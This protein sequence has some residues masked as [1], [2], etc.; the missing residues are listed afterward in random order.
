MNLDCR[1]VLGYENLYEV[2]RLGNVFSLRFGKRKILKP[3]FTNNYN[4]VSLYK[5][6]KLKTC[7]VHRIVAKVFL[8]FTDANLE[9]NHK[10]ENTID[11]CVN[12]LEWCTRQFNIEYSQS[13]SYEFV[14]PDGKLTKIFNLQKFCNDNYLDPSNMK[15]VIKGLRIHHRGWTKPQGT[16]NG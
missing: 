14:S 1:P 15:K 16:T 9:V 3:T 11:N 4:Y 8:G 12:N 10:N 13:K 5:D 7:S 2:D 6:K